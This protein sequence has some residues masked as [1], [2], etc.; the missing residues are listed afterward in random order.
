MLHK[1]TEANYC[2]LT[3]CIAE[4]TALTVTWQYP[5]CCIKT[6]GTYSNDTASRSLSSCKVTRALA[7]VREMARMTRCGCET[8]TGCSYE[9]IWVIIETTGSDSRIL[10]PRRGCQEDRIHKIRNLVAEFDVITVKLS[11]QR[12]RYKRKLILQWQE[13]W[14]EASQGGQL[15]NKC[16][17]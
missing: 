2:I 4:H 9:P 16:L 11:E 3:G 13:R 17:M 10:S 1:P 6:Q 7:C 8:V 5:Q 14:E 12:R 15:Q